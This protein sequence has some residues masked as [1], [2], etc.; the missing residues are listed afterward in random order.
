MKT[1]TCFLSFCCAAAKAFFARGISLSALLLLFVLHG[2][3]QACGDAGVCN[4][5]PMMAGIRDSAQTSGVFRAGAS[6]GLIFYRADVPGFGEETYL[7]TA[8]NP[9]VEYKRNVLPQLALTA[10]FSGG[11]RSGV[12]ITT[13]APADLMLTAETSAAG[14]VALW[15]GVKIPLQRSDADFQL[16]DLPMIYQPGMGTADLMA[17]LSYPLKDFVLGAALQ[18][19]VVQNKNRFDNTDWVFA[20]SIGAQRTTNRFHRQPDLVGRFMRTSKI[21]TSAFILSYGLVPIFHLGNDSFV[22]SDNQ[23]EAIDGSSGLT[24]NL[25]LILRKTLHHGGYWQLNMGAPAVARAV[26]PEGL[27]QVGLMFEVGLPG[28]GPRAAQPLQP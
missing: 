9:Y 4:I 24:L 14:P 12:F 18:Y 5:D 15:A 26:R 21:G 6:L 28:K 25:S 2:F 8:L 27:P 11:I 16:R 20:P 10:R 1:P 13:G 7:V 23:R 3:S 17:G 19:P 22:N